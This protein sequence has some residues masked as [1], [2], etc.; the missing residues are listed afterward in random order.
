MLPV[1]INADV[2]TNLEIIV[3]INLLTQLSK[4]LCVVNVELTEY[5]SICKTLDL[6]N[7]A[8][9][10]TKCTIT[11]LN[12]R[13]AINH[14]TSDAIIDIVATNAGN[15]LT[16]LDATVIDVVALD[17]HNVC[18]LLCCCAAFPFLDT[19]ITTFSSH[20]NYEFSVH[21]SY[22]YHASNQKCF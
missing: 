4:L 12:A 6:H 18:S 9:N 15:G 3:G 13:L 21:K 16:M 7:L 11:R 14:K 8:V 20:D 5:D 1:A 10:N 22:I 19:Y 2:L 17:S